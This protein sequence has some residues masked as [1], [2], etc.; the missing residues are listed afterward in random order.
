MNLFFK[1][2]TFCLV[3]TYFRFRSFFLVDIV[4][5]GLL[6]TFFATYIAYYSPRTPLLF[7]LLFYE[8]YLS[9]LFDE[10]ELRRLSRTVLEDLSDFFLSCCVV[11]SD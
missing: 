11:S 7:F 5:F 8:E 3:R 2:L 4:E 6:A 1:L 10:E 9:E